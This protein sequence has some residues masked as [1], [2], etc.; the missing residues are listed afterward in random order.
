MSPS[1][2][3]PLAGAL[4]GAVAGSATALAVAALLEP[5]LAQG[6]AQVPAS[7]PAAAAPAAPVSASRSAPSP[8]GLQDLEARVALLEARLERLAL[9]EPR[10]VVE[11]VTGSG[12]ER[13]RDRHLDRAFVLAVLEEEE[14]ARERRESKLV[15]R[16]EELAGE[17]GLSVDQR[18]ALAEVLLLHEDGCRALDAELAAA[19]L[20][21]EARRD[22]RQRGRRELEDRWR[23]E[24]ERR[25][26][27][28]AAARV[29]EA[30]R[31]HE[32][33]VHPGNA[34][35]RTLAVRD[36]SLVLDLTGDR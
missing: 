16:A 30:E 20:D 29:R 36:L 8:D 3:L 27:P 25:L 22:A 33:D 17:A 6:P 5:G 12:E 9:R 35:R 26:G 10:P 15:A 14:R 34:L 11:T 31:R 24:L 18:D 4:A 23:A 1:L 7:R 21:G 2:R 28:S 32:R 19:G 13:V